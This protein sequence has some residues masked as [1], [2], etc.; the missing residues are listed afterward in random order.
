MSVT[1]A[2]KQAEVEQIAAAKLSDEERKRRE[3]LG[4]EGVARVR[5]ERGQIWEHHRR[6]EPSVQAAW[7]RWEDRNPAISMPPVESVDTYELEEHAQNSIW[8]RL[9][10][11]RNVETGGIAKIYCDHLEKGEGW[12]LI[13]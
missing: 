12:R 2:D 1:A 4:A 9:V 7:T 8:S 5:L 11:L 3:Q 10:R 13:E 6:M